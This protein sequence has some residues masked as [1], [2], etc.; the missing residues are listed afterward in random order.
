MFYLLYYL[1]EKVNILIVLLCICL[2]RKTTWA[3]Q[4]VGLLV[5]DADGTLISVCWAFDTFAP[6]SEQDCGV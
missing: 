2:F 1:I 3:S 5:A 6:V 4:A